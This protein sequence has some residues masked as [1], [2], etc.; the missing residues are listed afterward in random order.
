MTLPSRGLKHA[1][2]FL[3]CVISLHACGWSEAP[4]AV[5]YWNS[6]RKAS[7]S[8]VKTFLDAAARGDS[9]N[10]GAVASDSL[11][12]P[13]LLQYRAI[14]G[15]FFQEM[16]ATYEPASV[17]VHGFGSEV[18]FFFTA[19]DHRYRGVAVLSYDHGS[20]KVIDL[21]APVTID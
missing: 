7:P 3:I 9:A 15:R 21:R 8:T 10:M 20:L 17:S 6:V 13:T 2:I 4:D 18:L 14:G 5:R 12:Q 1:T 19:D 16:A 11:V